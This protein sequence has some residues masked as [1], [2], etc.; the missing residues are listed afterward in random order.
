MNA[1]GEFFL[2]NTQNAPGDELF[3][4]IVVQDEIIFIESLD[5][6][7][8]ERWL[9]SYTYDD[10]T[11]V[12]SVADVIKI[13][14]SFLSTALFI[15]GDGNYIYVVN[16]GTEP[17]SFGIRSYSYDG[18]GNLSYITTY[19]SDN[20]QYYHG[21]YS[22]GYLFVCGNNGITT[23]TVSGGVLSKQSTWNSSP[24]IHTRIKVDG[25][26]LYS[27]TSTL[28]VMVFT[29]N[30]GTGLVSL[31]GND[32]QG[33]SLLDISIHR[34]NFIYSLRTDHIL[35]HRLVVGDID[36]VTE[37][38]FNNVH[39]S[40]IWSGRPDILIV[41]HKQDGVKSYTIDV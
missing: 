5:S 4:S 31:Y 11:G 39:F 9:R 26:H 27:I 29:W 12:M 23:F 10:F 20:A 33:T 7:A 28:G 32:Y 22:G 17:D 34:Y 8:N 2:L 38:T 41:T 36:Y 3:Y 6:I 18:A 37:Q 19:N 40:F 35:R 1:A 14:D 25:N 16:S 13:T 21:V 24:T 15:F 30:S